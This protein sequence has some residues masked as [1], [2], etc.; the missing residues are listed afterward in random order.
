MAA[1]LSY[2][3]WRCGHEQAIL[4]R[5]VSD[6]KYLFSLPYSGTVETASAQG[7]RI[8][9]HHAPHVKHAVV[10]RQIDDVM[11]SMLNIKMDGFSY[12]APRLRKIMEYGD[13]MLREVAAQP[14]VLT[15]NYSDLD[16]ERGCRQLFEHCLPYRFEL[17][18]WK[19][20]RDCNIQV[21]VPSVIRYYHEHRPEIETFK[22]DLWGELRH[23]RRSRQ[24]TRH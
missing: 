7:W 23:L 10:L 2:N 20:M 11:Q 17:G 22:S 8:I 1:F 9:T 4:L 24:I 21:N 16:T 19:H 13:R 12:D 15:L 6:I 18:W 5:S 14:G 3:E